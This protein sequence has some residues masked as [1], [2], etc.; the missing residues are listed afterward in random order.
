MSATKADIT[1][2]AMELVKNKSFSSFSYDDISRNLNMTKAAVHYHFK[3][4]EDLGLALCESLKTKFTEEHE[5]ALPEARKGRHPWKCLEARMKMVGNEGICPIVSLQSDFENLP[6]RLQDSL[7]ELTRLEIDNLCELARN[8]DPN[9][10]E[11]EV[12]RLLL[13]LKAAM[14]YRRAL[15]EKFFQSTIKGIKTRFQAICVRPN[16]LNG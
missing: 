7:S 16:N 14:Q 8:Y 9:V 12:I 13:S 15:G 5:K 1:S 6:E 2:L 10:D 11:N 4:K 3:N